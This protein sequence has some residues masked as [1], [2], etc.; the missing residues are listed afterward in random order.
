MTEQQARIWDEA[1]QS[2]G[3]PIRFSNLTPIQNAVKTAME[4]TPYLAT[5]HWALVRID[6][7]FLI[8]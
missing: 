5:R 7:R 3:P 1:T 6:R 8:T 2:C 4:L